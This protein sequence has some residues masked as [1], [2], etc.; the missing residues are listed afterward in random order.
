M[1][2]PELFGIA[3]TINIGN[4]VNAVITGQYAGHDGAPQPGDAYAVKIHV[5]QENTEQ[6]SIVAVLRSDS[7]PGTEGL[8]QTMLEEHMGKEQAAHVVATA[9]EKLS[10]H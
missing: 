10:S 3:Q 2:L 4:G 9:L 6:P 8:I 5:G 7:R 1:N